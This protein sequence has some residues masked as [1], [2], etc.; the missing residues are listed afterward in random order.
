MGNFCGAIYRK[1]TKGFFGY[2]YFE[3]H[4]NDKE[5]KF[6]E[7]GLGKQGIKIPVYVGEQQVALIEKDTHTANNLDSYNLSSVDGKTAQAASLFCV[8]YDFVRFGNHGEVS[9]NSKQVTYIY[10]GNKKLKEKYN[11]DWEC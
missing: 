2:Y 5:Y 10:T 4:L 8:Y 11:P 3:L 9:V 6:Y 7:I 1:R